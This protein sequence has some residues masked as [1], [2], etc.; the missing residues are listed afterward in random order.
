MTSR[1][2][3]FTLNNYT[4]DDLEEIKWWTVSYLVFGYETGENGTPHIQGYVE[5]N[6]TK[7]LTTLK[8][9]HTRI[10]WE[11]RKGN[12]LQASNYCKKGKQSHKEW[13]ELAELGPNFGLEA[14]VFE[15]G[16]VNKRQGK[17]TDLDQIKDMVKSGASMKEIFDEA[18]SFQAIKLAEIGMK[19]YEPERDWKTHVTWIWGPTGTGKSYQAYKEARAE[20]IKPWSAGRDLRWFER[21]D[22]D[23]HV[24]ID[25]FRGDFCT[26]HFLLKLLDRYP[27]MV[28]TKGGSRQF[29]AKR[30]WITS[31]YPPDRIYKKSD[32]D[33][34]Q[35]L[36]RIDK[37]IHLT[38]EDGKRLQ[39]DLTD[40]S[41]M[42]FI[43]EQ[44]LLLEQKSNLQNLTV[45]NVELPEPSLRAKVDFGAEVGGNTKTPTE[46]NNKYLSAPIISPWCDKQPCDQT[47]TCNLKSYYD[48]DDDETLDNVKTVDV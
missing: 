15:R 14:I 31:C 5:F 17:R 29:L 28:E 35:L 46:K 6:E 20:G 18:S 23:E 2:W 11:M 42:K 39:E 40:L 38:E 22:R 16:K 3:C 21:Y 12:R 19:L 4:E 25:D 41:I 1:N 44:K 8:K 47:H 36:R 7:R 45:K 27:L 26:F 33:V 43:K 24:I 9:L 30:I 34:K 13:E 10:H 48:L 32:E 37:T